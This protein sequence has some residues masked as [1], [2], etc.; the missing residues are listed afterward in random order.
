MPREGSDPDAILSRVEALINEDR[1][2]DA[3]KQINS[4]PTPGL[5]TLT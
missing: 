1:L 3:L 4:L 2:E 5:E